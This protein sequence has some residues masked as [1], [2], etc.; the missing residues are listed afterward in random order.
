MEE[1]ERVGV[2]LLKDTQRPLPETRKVLPPLYIITVLVW[3][4]KL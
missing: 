1:G 2:T 4:L 3:S